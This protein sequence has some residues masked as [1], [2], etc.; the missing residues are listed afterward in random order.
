MT[1]AAH[2][3]IPGAYVE[4]ATRVSTKDRV[5]FGERFVD[6]RYTGCG[7]PITWNSRLV[8]ARFGVMATN[9]ELSAHRN[10]FQFDI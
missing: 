7:L 6:H 1:R 5:I 4:H 2:I 9:H 8:R 10:R 3:R